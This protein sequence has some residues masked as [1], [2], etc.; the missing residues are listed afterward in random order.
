MSNSDASQGP[1]YIGGAKM[2]EKEEENKPIVEQVVN[3]L[4]SNLGKEN[5]FDK[6]I[7]AELGKLGQEGRLKKVEQV[8]AVIKPK[9]EDKK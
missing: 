6:E 7:L 2:G 1:E 9:S 4:L 3:E 8:I 5:E